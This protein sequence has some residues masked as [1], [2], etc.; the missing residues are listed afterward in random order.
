MKEKELRQFTTCAVCKK[1][2]GVTGS[3]TFWI[4]TAER[5]MLNIDAIERQEGLARMFGGNALLAQHMGPDDDMTEKIME[6]QKIMI[7]E[8]CGHTFQSINVLF[9]KKE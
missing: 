5:H 9:L 6:P 4:L 8:H 1:K 2:I 3:P 7:C